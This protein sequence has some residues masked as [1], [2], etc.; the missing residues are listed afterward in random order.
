[1]TPSSTQFIPRQHSPTNISKGMNT[2]P[3]TYLVLLNSWKNLDVKEV[4]RLDEAVGGHER[5]GEIVEGWEVGKKE[6]LGN[7][8]G[9]KSHHFAQIIPTPQQASGSWTSI[10]H[11]PHATWDDGIVCATAWIVGFGAECEHAERRLPQGSRGKEFRTLELGLRGGWRGG[12]EAGMGDRAA[13]REIKRILNIATNRVER[14]AFRIF[15]RRAI[16]MRCLGS[17]TS[18][19]SRATSWLV[20]RGL[21]FVRMGRE[22]D[23]KDGALRGS[24]V[25]ERRIE[26]L[27]DLRRRR[28]VESSANAAS[29]DVALDS[30]KATS[31]RVVVL[32]V[33][34]GSTKDFAP[35]GLTHFFRKSSETSSAQREQ[36]AIELHSQLSTSSDRGLF[37]PTKDGRW[38]M[39]KI[40]GGDKASVV[41]VSRRAF[42]RLRAILQVELTT[43]RTACLLVVTTPHPKSLTI[44]PPLYLFRVLSDVTARRET[45]AR[46]DHHPYF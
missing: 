26:Y 5:R 2:L 9:R 18:I 23:A 32:I 3:S 30:W 40:E 42:N 1:M 7:K 41:A 28:G 17:S 16:I 34:F 20:C 24:V 45:G 6:K 12:E 36:N 27:L 11:K 37:S 8:T 14:P 43:S 13:G 10:L 19:G 46:G 22:S 44:S 38:R 29:F 31:L 15:D 4:D 25:Q 21:V 35:L 39:M 33:A